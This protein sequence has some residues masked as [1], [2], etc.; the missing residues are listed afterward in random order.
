MSEIQLRLFGD[1]AVTAN[2][3]GTHTPNGKKA[4]GLLA[5]LATSESGSRKRRWLEN[6]LWSD[7]GP[8]QARGSLRTTLVALRRALGQHAHVLGSNRSSVWLDLKAVTTDLTQPH[9]GYEFLEGLDIKDPE[10][11]TWLAQQRARANL[12]AGSNSTPRADTRMLSIQ[13]GD[14]WSNTTPGSVS[15]QVVNDQIGKIVSEFIASSRCTV[16][17]TKS[18]LVI[19]TTIDEA[20]GGSTLFVQIID[21]LLDEIVH[22]DHCFTDDVRNF[23]RDPEQLGRFC[24]NLADLAL[25]KIPLLERNQSALGE[26]SAFA[27]SALRHVLSFEPNQMHESLSVLSQASERLDAGLYSALRAWALTSMIMEGFHDENAQ[28]LE[29]IKMYL[30]KAQELAPGE[31]MV[32]AICANVKSILF[33]DFNEASALAR[34]ALRENPNNI[35]ALQALSASRAAEGRANLA[36]ELSRH[37]QAVSSLS[38]FGAMCNLHHALLCISMQRGDEAIQSSEIA[39]DLAPKYRAPRR[40]MLALYAAGGKQEQTQTAL[41]AM[42]NVEPDFNLDRYL[43]DR[44]YPSNTLRKSGYLEKAMKSLVR[45]S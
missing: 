22:S 42:R 3:G 2:E 5:L 20:A 33:E 18:D 6:K 39:I 15:A 45:D 30:I 44:R 38:K 35:F 32:A 17:D 34:R 23:I 37:A 8:D 16:K 4:I 1:F 28:T 9:P 26:R 19:R 25:E 41:K 36:Y 21:P 10:F 24:W 40:Q 27:Q 7:R 13:C 11:N 31:G 43:F 12:D 29:E 14:P